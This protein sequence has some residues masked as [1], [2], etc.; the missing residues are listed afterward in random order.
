MADASVDVSELVL[1]PWEGGDIQHM[2]ILD[3]QGMKVPQE[4]RGHGRPS[5]LS[6]TGCNHRSSLSITRC[7]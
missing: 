1:K 5:R 3:L 7:H 4:Q 6:L 2:A